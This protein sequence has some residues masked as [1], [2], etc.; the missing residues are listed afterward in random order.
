MNARISAKVMIG[1]VV[2]GLVGI[3]FMGCSGRMRQVRREGDVIE[4]RQRWSRGFDPLP[5]EAS[6]TLATEYLFLNMYLESPDIIKKVRL[7]LLKHLAAKHRGDLIGELMSDERAEAKRAAA[8]LLASNDHVTRIF[9]MNRLLKAGSET[10]YFLQ[11]IIDLWSHLWEKEKRTLGHTLPKVI[12]RLEE[13]GENERIQELAEEITALMISNPGRIVPL[14]GIRLAKTLGLKSEKVI[15]ALEK[16]RTNE[17]YDYFKNEHPIRKAALE[18]LEESYIPSEPEKVDYAAIS[19]AGEKG[20]KKTR[21]LTVGILTSLYT[22]TG[23]CSGGRD[24]YGWGGQLHLLNHLP[25]EKVRVLGYSHPITEVDKSPVAEKLKRAGYSDTF[26]NSAS[27][28]DLSLC[29]VVVLPWIFNIRAEVV[30][31]LEKNRSLLTD[32][33]KKLNETSS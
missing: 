16:Q 30:D 1:L 21:R 5:E 28:E 22:A 3:A 11:R 6:L 9:I 20:L 17:I 7:L 13:E 14:T 2:I 24:T 26:L 18:A 29:D 23:P 25:K 33:G 15:S 27:F 19:V 10:E 31:A 4:P 12:S 32:I 8:D